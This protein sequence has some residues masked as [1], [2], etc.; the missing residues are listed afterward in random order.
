M[1]R[2]DG[3]DRV[4]SW[5]M[6]PLLTPTRYNNPDS[7]RSIFHPFPMENTASDLAIFPTQWLGIVLFALAIASIILGLR[8]LPGII[9]RA[10]LLLLPSQAATILEKT[11]SPFKGLIRI[12]FL[13]AIVDLILILWDLD[14]LSP[15]GERIVSLSLTVAT[16][17][18]ASRIFQQFFDV[19]L[20]DAAFQSGRKVNSELLIVSKWTVNAAIII[21]AILL[22]AQT[23]QVNVIGLL[24]SLGVGGL[25]IAFAAQNT[26]SQFLGGIV[27]YIDRPFVVDDYIG[28][29]D[30]T[31]GRV[32]SIGLRSTK[33]RTSGKGTLMIVPNNSLT[34]V[35][36]ENFTGAKKV[37]S[38]LYLTFYRIIEE[39]E[40]ALIREVILASTQDIFGI[41]PRS[42]NVT[43]RTL[44]TG[45]SEAKTQAQITLFILGSGKASMDIRRQMIDRARQNI[46]VKLKEYGVQ[47]DIE[48]PNIYVDSPITI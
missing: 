13:F 10:I 17:V 26:L 44:N 33:I 20:I 14:F 38:L 30:G 29:P 4:S 31:F 34:Q 1:G 32:E 42:T 47:F 45:G 19:Y 40:Q 11:I 6:I 8:A 28:L 46:T 36:I 22:F 24:A 9:L 5:G 39:Q 12:V 23:H 43:F 16:S 7:I 18:L 3:C 21:L 48:E 25:A 15:W 35:N 2:I 41:N 27:L 37:M